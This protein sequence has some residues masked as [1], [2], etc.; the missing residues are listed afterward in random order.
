MNTVRVKL[1]QLSTAE[2]NPRKRLRPGEP[3]YEQLKRSIETFGYVDPIIA[4]KDGTIIG[5]HQRYY[6]LIDL[7]YDEVDIV[8]LDI[9]KEKEKA[10]NLAMNK[11]SGEWDDEKLKD[12]LKDLD[13]GGFD[14]EI[15]GFTHNEF[16]DLIEALEIPETVE[17]DDFD[18]E[19]EYEAI[20]TPQTVYGDIYIL[21]N[22]RLMCGDSTKQEDVDE[23]MGGEEADLVVTDPPYN[24]NYGDKA[25]Y[26]EEYLGKGSRNQHSIKN[27]N[28][29][30]VSFYHFLLD[31][32]SQVFRVMRNGA[33]IYVFHGENEGITF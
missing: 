4:N 5:G 20:E 7:G 1:S 22:H 24:V 9:S 15:T 23:L 12:L 11:I 16:N 14:I 25:Q 6:I 3:E 18:P 32:F 17:D 33:A 30:E 29:D 28:M 31:A 27:D 8:Q 21:G 13:L 10:L 19:E 26:L 2:Y